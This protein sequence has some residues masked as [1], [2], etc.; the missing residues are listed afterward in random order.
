MAWSME[1]QSVSAL[2][3]AEHVA[4]AQPVVEPHRETE[5]RVGTSH[6]PPRCRLRRRLVE[7]FRLVLAG[8]FYSRFVFS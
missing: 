8:L 7:C 4:K 5:L 1:R 2:D 6:D 3:L